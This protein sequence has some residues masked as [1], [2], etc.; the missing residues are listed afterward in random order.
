MMYVAAATESGSNC[1]VVDINCRNY[2]NNEMKKLAISSF[3]KN[4]EIICD[5][6]Y[7]GLDFYKSDLEETNEQKIIKDA[8]EDSYKL[9]RKL[10][11][12]IGIV[13]PN[14]G[15]GMRFSL[16]E[17][18]IKFLVLSIIPPSGKVTLDNFAKMLYEHFGMVIGQDEYL[19]EMKKGCA[20]DVGDL[21]F[22]NT[23]KKAF[24]QKLKDCGFL[25]DLSD[26]TSIVENPYESESEEL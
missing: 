24:A 1:W 16:S 14:T 23:N 12:N 20:E 19:I 6:L 3:K 10:G 11:K 18:I 15:K 17:D 2:D 9:F 8:A 4:E 22:L 25:R 21:S 13:I 7:K 5:Y 26:A